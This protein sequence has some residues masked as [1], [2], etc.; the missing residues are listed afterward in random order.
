MKR[1]GGN[2]SSHGAFTFTSHHHTS[3]RGIALHGPWAFQKQNKTKNNNTNVRKTSPPRKPPHTGLRRAGGGVPAGPARLSPPPR[4]RGA[5]PGRHHGGAQRGG[6]G[7]P[8]FFASPRVPRV[9]PGSPGPAMLRP[10]VSASPQELRWLQAAEDFARRALPTRQG[11]GGA[12]PPPSPELA[13]V[14][15]CLR[16]A[17]RGELPLGY[18]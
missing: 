16:G 5:E 1:G 8:G 18:R 6:E 4:C 17:G 12:E 7:A 3:A 13:A 2:H 10:R 9:P 14:L 15:G 11:S